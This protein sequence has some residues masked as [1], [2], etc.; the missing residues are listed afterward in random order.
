[1]GRFSFRLSNQLSI[2]IQLLVRIN[3][4]DGDIASLLNDL[5]CVRIA[6]S[7][8]YDDCDQR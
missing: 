4:I 2:K 7:S 5:L 3:P 1:M 8:K 6:A